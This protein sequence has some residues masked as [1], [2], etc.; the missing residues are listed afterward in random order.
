MNKK[1]S[2]HFDPC[3]EL[4]NTGF[5]ATALGFGDLA[6]RAIPLATLVNTV[7]RAIDAGLNG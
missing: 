3:R 4:G 6:D 5:I 1:N 7:R 2:R